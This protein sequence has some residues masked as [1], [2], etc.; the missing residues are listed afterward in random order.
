MI[1]A[2]SGYH[3]MGRVPNRIDRRL[4]YLLMAG[5]VLIAASCGPGRLTAPGQDSGKGTERE[6]Q[7]SG[8]CIDLNSATAEE[9]TTLPGIGAVLSA[10]IVEYRQRNGPFRRPEDIIIINGISERKFRRLAGL[11]CVRNPDSSGQHPD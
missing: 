9:L 11:V 8:P 3:R 10:R 1:R 6:A 5:L 2:E 7:T 4:T